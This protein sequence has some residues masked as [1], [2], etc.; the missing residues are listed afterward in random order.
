MWKINTDVAFDMFTMIQP[1]IRHEKKLSMG[2]YLTLL[3]I[4]ETQF[5]DNS[6]ILRVISEQTHPECRD[7]RCLP[8]DICVKIRT[9]DGI[10]NVY[11]EIDGEQHFKNGFFS[12]GHRLTDI[13]THD[14]IKTTFVIDNDDIIVRI[15]F[16]DNHRINQIV[17][18]VFENLNT[19]NGMYTTRPRMY[20]YL[21]LEEIHRIRLN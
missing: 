7:Q 11:F 12:Q 19:M 16:R 10:I 2:H 9:P 5:D 14:K 20:Q 13:Q 18:H 8:F 4:N 15:P 1:Q 21:D 3:A 17:N 6:R